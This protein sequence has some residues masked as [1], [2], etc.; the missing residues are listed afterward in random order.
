MHVTG[1]RAGMRRFKVRDGWGWLTAPTYCPECYGTGLR[2]YG[3]C[4]TCATATSASATDS[5][6]PSYG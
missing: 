2:P 5:K 1:W 4:R 3:A 6:E